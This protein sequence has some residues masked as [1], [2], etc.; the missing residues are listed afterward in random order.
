ME[1][2]VT[3]LDVAVD[4]QYEE[5]RRLFDLYRLA[6]LNARYYGCR[7]ETFE[8]RN[9]GALIV[10]AAF[11]MLALSLILA[12]PNDAIMRGFAA[13]FAGLAGLISGVIPFFGWTDKV[14]EL[15]NQHFAYSQIFGQIEF[16]IAEI[17]RTGTLLPEHIGMAKMAHEGYMRIEASD[18]L[19]P[20]QKLINREDAKVRKAFPEDYLWTH[21]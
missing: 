18:E 21:F 6:N 12:F 3:R 16:A 1:E 11:S 5:L 2:T 20:D 13:G 8:K 14:R 19:E 10:T 9:K 4:P 7:A 15:R 17:R